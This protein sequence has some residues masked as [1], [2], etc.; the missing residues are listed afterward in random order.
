MRRPATL[1]RMLAVARAEWRHNYRDARSLAI[2]IALPVFL[3]LIYGYGINLDLRDLP[4]AVQD[5]DRTEQSADFVNRLVRSDY[6]TL[7]RA[8]QDTREI[9]SVIEVGAVRFVLVIPHGFGGDLA[10]GRPAQVQVV[11]D[12]GDSATASVALGYLEALVGDHSIHLARR[13]AMRHGLPASAVEP[14]L[15][16]VPRVLYNPE[17]RSVNF[18]VPGLIAVILTLL[19]ALLTSGCIVR[20]REGGSFEALAASPIAPIEI[21]LGKLLPYAVISF[22]DIVLCMVVGRLLFGVAP[23]G[24]KALLLGLSL[25]YLI[26]SLSIGLLV[27]SLAR[28]HQVATLIAFLATV[29][30]SLL[31]SGFAFPVRSMPVALQAIAQIIPA[32]HF[33]III[34]AIYLKGAG[35]SAFAP[36]VAALAAMAL[37]LVLL[38]VRTFRKRLE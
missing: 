3:L 20:E 5:L 30:P 6:F 15:R 38:T 37:A 23:M 11:L 34:R 22:V 33:L 27:S 25:I 21:V 36:R 1:R 13:W 29:L 10:S 4:F 8:I 12:G 9:D 2:V 31:V 24:D 7:A 16:V 35:V 26:A 17:L 18:I 28:S 19:A 32:T 14:A